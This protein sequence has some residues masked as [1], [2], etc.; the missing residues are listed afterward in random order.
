MAKPVPSQLLGAISAALLWL[1]SG[2]GAPAVGQFLRPEVRG[3]FLS[4]PLADEPRD[5]LLP[6]PPVDRPLSPLEKLALEADL[7]RLNQQATELLAANESEVAYELWMREV[8]LRRLLGFDQELAAI[9][10]VGQRV[11][12]AG[13]SQEVRLLTARLRDIHPQLME[14]TPDPERLKQVAELFAL[15]GEP[16]E[17]IAIYRQLAELS[18][19]QGEAAQYKAYLETIAQIQR[20]WFQFRE[21]ALS[22]QELYA[23]E[24]A[25]VADR[26]FYLQEIADSYAQIRQYQQALEVQQVLLQF[27]QWQSQIEPIPALR[28]SMG[29]HHYQLNQL[30]A[31]ARQYQ[32]AY[33]QAISLPQYEVASQSIEDL[34]NLYQQL[35]R[36]DDRIYLYRQLILVEQKAYDAYGIMQ[37]YDQLAQTYEVLNQPEAALEAY[38]EGLVMASHVDQR[39]GYFRAQIRRLDPDSTWQEGWQQ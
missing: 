9:E 10:R 31:A 20:Q 25:T 21:A 18:Q 17:A 37:A 13:R 36:N 4:N 11:W 3:P 35:D 28:L 33:E 24:L 22:Y 8:R 16:D 38:R 30:E 23:L 12:D 32:Q 14:P 6:D 2:I 34:A 39:Q 27:Y 15:L 29:H 7:D 19:A 1:G 5:P 26:I